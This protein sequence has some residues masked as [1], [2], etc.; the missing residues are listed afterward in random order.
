MKPKTYIPKDEV[1]Q[2]ISKTFKTLAAAN[3][4]LGEDKRTVFEEYLKLKERIDKLSEIYAIRIEE[5]DDL[6]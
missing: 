3:P 6:K 2:E 5:E 4:F 1:I